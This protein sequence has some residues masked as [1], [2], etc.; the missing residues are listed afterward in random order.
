MSTFLLI[1]LPFTCPS[2]CLHVYLFIYL[3]IYL[4]TCLS[5][6]LHVYLSVYMS[7]Y[8][9]T[10]LT[11]CLLVYL[12]ILVCLSGCGQ[13]NLKLTVCRISP[14]FTLFK[15]TSLPFYLWRGGINYLY[16]LF[17]RF[18]GERRLNMFVG[19]NQGDPHFNTIEKRLKEVY[20]YLN[21]KV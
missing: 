18:N 12:A 20:C 6:Y 15:G 11:I 19:S 21:L 2:I 13:T 9:S 3:S 17:P 10:S 14:L 16:N 5:I 4:S 8:L 1:Y 7:I